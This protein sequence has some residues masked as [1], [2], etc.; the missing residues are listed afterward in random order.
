MDHVLRKRDDQIPVCRHEDGVDND[1]SFGLV[2]KASLLLLWLHPQTTP[3]FPT[4]AHMPHTQTTH[5][6]VSVCTLH[7]HLPTLPTSPPDA[8]A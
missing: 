4:N 2:Q 5:N 3:A 8:P 7:P 1:L 6:A